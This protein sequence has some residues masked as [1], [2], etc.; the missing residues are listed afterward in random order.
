MALA[1]G[2]EF[3]TTYAIHMSEHKDEHLTAMGKLAEAMGEEFDKVH[4]ER[5]QPIESCLLELQQNQ[6]KIVTVVQDLQMQSIGKSDSS[7]KDGSTDLS[8]AEVEKLLD[9]NTEFVDELR[10]NFA[11][12]S[13][14]V[15]DLLHRQVALGS[16]LEVVRKD[17]AV[18]PSDGPWIAASPQ[19]SLQHSP[20]QLGATSQES[21]SDTKR[22]ENPLKPSPGMMSD[23]TRTLHKD[24]E[25][26]SNMAGDLDCELSRTGINNLERLNQKVASFPLELNAIRKE[27]DAKLVEVAA[28]LGDEFER[29]QAGQLS[30]MVLVLGEEFD[31]VLAEKQE[32]LEDS[33]VE[34]QQNQAR[35]VALMEGLIERQEFDKQYTDFLEDFKPQNFDSVSGM[36]NRLLESQAALTTEFDALRQTCVTQDPAGGGREIVQQEAQM[37]SILAKK[38]KRELER[39]N[40][41]GSADQAIGKLACLPAE[42]EALRITHNAQLVRMVETLGDEFEKIHDIKMNDMAFALGEEFDKLQGEKNGLLQSS[43]VELKQNQAKLASIVLKQEYVA[44]LSEFTDSEAAEKRMGPCA[45]YESLCCFV[46]SEIDQKVEALREHLSAQ[47]L[48]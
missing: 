12:L 32:P 2:E 14:V 19:E 40:E 25:L 7:T 18:K 20:S 38:I 6:E 39:N 17:C 3:G 34:L 8:V 15:E 4:Q 1:L 22:E 36:I 45:E 46:R 9:A 33:V 29:S 43:L 28:A 27:Q 47:V 30:D 21:T 37:L 42:F 26:M 16:E 10:S 11:K 24:V 13:N 35:M 44:S 23:D 41:I 31:K 5:S 48:Q